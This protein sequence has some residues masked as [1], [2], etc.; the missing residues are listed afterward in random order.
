[1]KLELRAR[2]RGD[3]GGGDAAA[4]ANGKSLDEASVTYLLDSVVKVSS[5]EY[6]DMSH[7]DVQSFAMLG[8]LTK[9]LGSNTTNLRCL[10]L[11]R[12]Q[13]NVCMEQYLTTHDSD[14][15]DGAAAATASRSSCDVPAPY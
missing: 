13:R 5:L 10:G 6:L 8:R 9:G 4:Q 2:V 3:V 12:Y 11:P 14:S 15:A 7:C 1:M